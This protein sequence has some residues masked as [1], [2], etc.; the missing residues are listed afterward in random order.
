MSTA[1]AVGQRSA[2]AG[3]PLLEARNLTL[4]RGERCLFEDMSFSLAAGELVHLR[5]PNGCGK[6]S[7]LRVICGLTLPESGEV[8][9]R[10]SQVL[11]NRTDF[12]AEMSYVGHRESLKAELSAEE[13][14]LHDLGL[15]RALEPGAVQEALKSVQLHHAM[16]IPS[17]SLS[18]GQKRRVSLAR[19]LASKSR[20]WILDEPY[21]NLDIAGRTLV[22]SMMT[23]HLQQDGIV[24]LVAH[25][26]HGV[27]HHT[28][29]YLEMD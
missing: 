25:Q 21:T 16:D 24:L 12:H 15:R 17:R 26:D 5:G 14:L 6:T 20:L 4:W 10:D 2:S 28:I 19:C 13:N 22:D 27:D 29:N 3:T 8:L 7:L 1:N 18:A 23:N 11:S 9:W